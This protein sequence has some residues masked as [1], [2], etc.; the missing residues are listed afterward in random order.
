MS[1][2]PRRIAYW[3]HKDVDRA[4]REHAMIRPNDRVAVA[5]YGGKGSLSL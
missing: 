2:D 4:I 5:V 1:S 3:L